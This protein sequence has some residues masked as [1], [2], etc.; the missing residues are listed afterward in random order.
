MVDSNEAGKLSSL[1]N[2]IVALE[3]QAKNLNPRMERAESKLEVLLERLTRAE[4]RMTRFPAKEQMVK[5]EERIAHLPTKELMFSI[6][7]SMMTFIIA[8]F[9]FLEKIKAFFGL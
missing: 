7:A 6:V 2:R 8:V 4:E 1:E 9:A 3:I 5:L